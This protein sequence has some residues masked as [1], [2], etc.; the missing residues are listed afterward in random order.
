MNEIITGKAP[1]VTGQCAE[2]LSI[3]RQNQPVLSFT[4]TADHAIPETAARVHDLRAAGYN[5]ITVIVPAVE[6]RGKTR[7]NAALYSLG[8]PEW[9]RPGFFAANDEGCDQ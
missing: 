7:R 1:Q 4:L 9:P 6:F 8:T 5:I 2:V 3:I